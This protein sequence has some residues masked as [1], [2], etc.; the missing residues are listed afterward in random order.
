MERLPL[1]CE[2]THFLSALIALY[3]DKITPVHLSSNKKI[4]DYTVYSIN[5][6]V[7]LRL[8]SFSSLTRFLASIVA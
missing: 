7:A 6:A 4:L 3:Q 8:P 1:L 2:I 5:Q